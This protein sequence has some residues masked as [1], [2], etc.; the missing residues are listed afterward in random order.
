MFKEWFAKYSWE[1][2]S[3]LGFLGVVYVGY[4]WGIKKSISGK[5]A[6][7][8]VGCVIAAFF[9]LYLLGLRW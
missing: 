1:G 3:F 8:Y 7:L 6:V 2:F 4:L 9:L 5:K